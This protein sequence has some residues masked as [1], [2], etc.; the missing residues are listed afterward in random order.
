[1]KRWYLSIK[2]KNNVGI[3]LLYSF[4]ICKKALLVDE[5]KPFIERHILKIQFGS[6]IETK[7]TIAMR[8]IFVL[9]FMIVMGASSWAKPTLPAKATAHVSILELPLQKAIRVAV[10]GNP[11]VALLYHQKNA[12][13]KKALTFKVKRRLPKW[14]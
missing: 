6:C 11:E 12:R 7:S 1:M 4:F 10:P 2:Y 13:I 14:A 5:I 8:T 9:F 3:Y